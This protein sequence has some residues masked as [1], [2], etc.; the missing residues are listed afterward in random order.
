MVSLISTS[1]IVIVALLFIGLVFYAIFKTHASDVSP[2]ITK[3]VNCPV[4]PFNQLRECNPVDPASCKDCKNG[5]FACF[6]VDKEHPYKFNTDPNT[7]C[8]TNPEKCVN[9]PDGTWCLPVIVESDKCNLWTS[10][11]ILT[12]VDPELWKWRCYCKYPNLVQ[13]TGID[14]DCNSVIACVFL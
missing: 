5:E 11:P 12:E 2:P 3:T 1:I 8:K 14:G 9:V 10:I 4:T 13:K 6:T 7:D